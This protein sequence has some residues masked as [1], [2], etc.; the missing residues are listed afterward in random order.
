M[1]EQVGWRF[2]VALVLAHEIGHRIGAIRKLRWA[3]ID[4]DSR[5]VRWRAEHEKTGFE[6]ITPLTDEAVAALEEARRI[7]DGSGN[8][9]G[10]PSSKDAT[11]C[12]SRVC[13]HNW[14]RKAQTLAGLE[15]KDMTPE[16]W[17]PHHCGVDL[18]ER[19]CAG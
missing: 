18:R 12:M 15:P 10:L 4:F 16:S 19:R 1:S 11:Q 3:D 13:A 14:W 8:A 17:T 9:P 6:H 2:H 5:E 7:S